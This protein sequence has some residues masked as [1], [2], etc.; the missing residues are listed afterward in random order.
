MAP[1]RKNGPSKFESD[2][3]FWIGHPVDPIKQMLL[4]ISP[5]L[6]SRESTIQDLRE[7][8]SKR[9]SISIQS[10]KHGAPGSSQRRQFSL[11]SHPSAMNVTLL[12]EEPSAVCQNFR[13]HCKVSIR[14]V[15]YLWK[16]GALKYDLFTPDRYFGDEGTPQWRI[17]RIK[18]D[19]DVPLS[20]HIDLYFEQRVNNDP[21]KDVRTLELK[22][23][24]RMR[25][26][27]VWW[28]NN[29]QNFMELR[30]LVAPSKNA[31]VLINPG[32]HVINQLRAMLINDNT[33]SAD[34]EAEWEISNLTKRIA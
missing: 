19:P 11:T 13:V 17:H 21:T 31:T 1:P 29:P 25:L 14:L 4:G 30:Y 5:A 20:E 27:R 9:R 26:V 7:F 2:Q 6:L 3:E 8:V 22:Y 23:G 32:E 34:P 33:D 16:I 12:T 10:G 15:R 24:F 28:P 18:I